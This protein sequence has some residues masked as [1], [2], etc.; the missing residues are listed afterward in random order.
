MFKKRLKK[1]IINLIVYSSSSQW[2]LDARSVSR[3]LLKGLFLLFFSNV[4]VICESQ[5]VIC[6][7]LQKCLLTNLTLNHEDQ[8][9]KKR[10]IF[11]LVIIAYLIEEWIMQLYLTFSTR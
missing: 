9:L 2:P 4:M 8:Y 10:L 6:R 5:Y 11:R 1:L 3:G 7:K